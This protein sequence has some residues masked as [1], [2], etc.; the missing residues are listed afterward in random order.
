MSAT[1]R[2]KVNAPSPLRSPQWKAGDV[3]RINYPGYHAHGRVVT[4][5][6][7]GPDRDSDPARRRLL[8]GTDMAVF[9]FHPGVRTALLVNKLAPA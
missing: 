2:F 5:I 6:E 3:V 8:S 7:I 9:E 1:R 4:I